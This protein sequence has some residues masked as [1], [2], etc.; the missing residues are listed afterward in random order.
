MKPE[1]EPSIT[2]QKGTSD[3]RD[4]YDILAPIYKTRQFYEEGSLINI[5]DSVQNNKRT[6]IGKNHQATLLPLSLYDSSI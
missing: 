4:K 2:G 5:L 6:A 3:N 1:Q